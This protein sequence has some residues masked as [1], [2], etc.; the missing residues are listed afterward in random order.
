[1]N[2]LSILSLISLVLAVYFFAKRYLAKKEMERQRMHNEW[3]KAQSNPS[4]PWFGVS[5]HGPLP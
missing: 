3:V 2:V 1:M 4:H 5:E